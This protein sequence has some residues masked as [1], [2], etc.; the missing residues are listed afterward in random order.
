M[1]NKIVSNYILDIV[2]P[3]NI[4][5]MT[6]SGFMWMDSFIGGSLFTIGI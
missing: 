3:T 2:G 4:A 1:A 6:G 5:L